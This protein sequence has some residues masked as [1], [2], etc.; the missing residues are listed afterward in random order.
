VKHLSDSVLPRLRQIDGVLECHASSSQNG[1]SNL[2]LRLTN[3][4]A[5]LPQVLNIMVQSSAEVCDCQIHELPLE[6]IFTHALGS[7]NVSE[8]N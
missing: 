5:V 7:S 1:T 3:R 6:D 2:E 8:E 4:L